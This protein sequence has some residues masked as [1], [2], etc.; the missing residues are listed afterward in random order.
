MIEWNILN[1]ERTIDQIE[2]LEEY[3][4]NFPDSA[5]VPVFRSTIAEL[6]EKIQ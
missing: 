6:E 2:E 3:I 5:L 1:E 4:A